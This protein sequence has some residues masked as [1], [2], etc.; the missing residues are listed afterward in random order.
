MAQTVTPCIR[1]YNSSSS[2]SVIYHTPPQGRSILKTALKDVL[3]LLA[4]VAVCCCMQLREPLD[5]PSLWTNLDK[6]CLG[7]YM[8]SAKS[9]SVIDTV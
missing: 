5:I 9:L 3:Y 7:I 2:D 4:E 6:Y 1:S 8:Y